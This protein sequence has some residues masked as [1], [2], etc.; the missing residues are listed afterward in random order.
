MMQHFVFGFHGF[1]V[2]DNI[3]TLIKEYYVGN[4]ILMKRNIQSTS[5]LPAI[6][7]YPPPY[8][9]PPFISCLP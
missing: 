5:L 8:P 1:E 3:R 2:S 7:A 6:H 4:V 9:N